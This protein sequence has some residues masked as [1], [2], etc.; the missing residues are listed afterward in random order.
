MLF[1]FCLYGFLKNQQYYDFF[2]MLAFMEKGL[3]FLTIGVL[4][5][6]REVCINLM[7]IPT[8]AI[9]D[10]LGRRR[11]MIASFAAYIAAFAIF[12]LS[13]RTWLLF[14]AML[15][16]AVGE[17][18]R[19]GTHKAIIFDW[20]KREGRADEKTAIYGRTRAWSKLGSAVSVL[21]AAA[22]VYLTDSYGAIFLACIVPYVINIVNFLGYPAYLDGEHTGSKNL[23]EILRVLWQSLRESFRHSKVRRLLIEAMNFEGTY[24]SAKDYVQPM[25]QAAALALPFAFAVGLSDKR[26]TALLVALV[27]SALYL[28]SSFASRHSGAVARAAGGEQRASRLLWAVDFAAFAAIVAGVLA[29]VP[30]IAIAAFVVLAVLQNLW[31]PMLIS[32]LADLTESRKMATVLSIESQSKSLFAAA[33]C[34]LLG[35]FVDSLP[36]D[37]RLWPVGAMGCAVTAAMLLTGRRR[38]KNEFPDRREAAS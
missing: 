28:L 36:A 11:A 20:L 2:M 10:V 26:S 34:P 19:T 32:R 9:A 4:F 29:G 8:G 30:T 13:Q 21:I 7:E 35:W 38:E 33:V 27:G 25:I 5:G 18:F 37:V 31:R 17:A 1:R 16:F 23:G 24:K 3:S 22:M 14:P 6:F 15:A 12:G